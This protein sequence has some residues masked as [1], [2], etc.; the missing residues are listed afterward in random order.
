MLTHVC[1]ACLFVGKGHSKKKKRGA[2][3][4]KKVT[5]NSDNILGVK[6]EEGGPSEAV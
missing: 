3:V 1:L 5:L 2:S 4:V 6:K